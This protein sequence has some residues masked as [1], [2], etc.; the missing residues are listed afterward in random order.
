MSQTRAGRAEYIV[1]KTAFSGAFAVGGGFLGAAVTQGFGTLER[2]DALQTEANLKVQSNQLG[3]VALIAK[4]SK[5]P[6]AATAYKFATNE[7]KAVENKIGKLEAKYPNPKI[8]E[9]S[10]VEAGITGSLAIIGA[11]AGALLFNELANKQVIKP[12]FTGRAS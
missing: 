11:V 6:D 10:P 2:H 5:D 1:A 9:L 7:Q 3:A 4:K 8:I 12:R